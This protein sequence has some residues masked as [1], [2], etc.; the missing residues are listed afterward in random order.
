M[1]RKSQSPDNGGT[2]TAE[3]AER[4]TRTRKSPKEKAETLTVRVLNALDSLGCMADKLTE[5]QREAVVTAVKAKL[6]T[7]DETFAES[8]DES[9]EPET[10]SLPE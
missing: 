10:F 6:A 3:K 5:P 7:L 4:K 8:E 9:E 2:A 1:A